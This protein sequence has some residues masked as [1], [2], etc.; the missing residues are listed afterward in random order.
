MPPVFCLKFIEK[1]T[2][3]FN[4]FESFL[5]SYSNPR[6]ENIYSCSFKLKWQL[7][8]NSVEVT[9]SLSFSF[10]ILVISYLC[11]IYSQTSSILLLPTL[12]DPLR[13][14]LYVVV[15]YYIENIFVFI[16]V[17]NPIWKYFIII[18]HNNVFAF[19]SRFFKFGK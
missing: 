16:C 9:K 7:S 1:I 17:N 3:A 12:L 4:V 2:L 6:R 11:N 13:L 10:L 15:C 18:T 5:I 14:I 8:N 19:C